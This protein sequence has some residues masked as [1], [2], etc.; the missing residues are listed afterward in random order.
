M[1]IEYRGVDDANLAALLTAD[2]RAFGQ[3]AR[4]PGSPDTWARLELERARVAVEGAEVVGVGRNYSFE[5]TMPGGG[6]LPAA[7]VS[8]IG[9]LPTHRRRG[10]LRQMMRELHDDARA[11]GEAVSILTASESSIYGRFGYGIATWQLGFSIDP[12]YSAFARPVDGSGSVRFVD[13]ATARS[14]LPPL[15]ESVRPLRAGMVSR[16]EGWWDEAYFFAEPD[17]AWFYVVHADASGADD[18]FAQ[19]KIDSDWLGSDGITNARMTVLDVQA[20]TDTARVAL[21]R[22]L[23][24]VD[25]VAQVRVIGAPIDDP[26]R[27]WLAEPRRLRVDYVNDRLYVAVHDPVAALG[28]RSY[29]ASGS[30]VIDVHGADGEVR[31]ALE[32]GDGVSATTTTR[33]ADVALGVRELGSVLLGGV[34]WRE[35]AAAGLIDEHVPGALARAD[36]LFATFPAPATLSWF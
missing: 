32:A 18:G 10:V 16:P 17:E 6:V 28:A 27:W 19:Y 1:D 31:V 34:G 36:A 2:A 35:L 15:Y 26:V 30:L 21:W 3:A 22:Y 33:S 20:R 25:L 29:S 7:A 23:F 13:D 8:W 24:D 11:H 9:V 14:L 5:L 4:K 12:R